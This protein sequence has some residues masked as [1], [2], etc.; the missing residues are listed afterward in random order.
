M[1]YLVAIL[2]SKLTANQINQIKLSIIYQ[3][4]GRPLSSIVHRRVI[5]QLPQWWLR[6]YNVVQS[7]LATER[8]MV[9]LNQ[10]VYWF[11]AHK[12]HYS[13]EISTNNRN[14][15]NHPI[16]TITFNCCTAEKR[17]WLFGNA[18]FRVNY[19]IPIV[20]KMHCNSKIIVLTGLRYLWI[21]R[22]AA[23]RIATRERFTKAL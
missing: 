10:L 19:M 9:T 11:F 15:I 17:R 7:S 21:C 13:H 22:N 18:L 23:S 4:I 12:F 2:Y 1:A 20:V 8:M 14:Q 6:S 3:K 5:P 16:N